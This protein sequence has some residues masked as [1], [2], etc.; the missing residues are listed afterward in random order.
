MPGEAWSPERFSGQAQVGPTCFW[1]AKQPTLQVWKSLSI[2]DILSWQIGL[3][4]LAAMERVTFLKIG[5]DESHRG[6][7]YT[8]S[9]SNKQESCVCV[10]GFF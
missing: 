8:P 9:H 1:V 6:K 10:C 5:V 7:Q 3:S 4:D 2:P